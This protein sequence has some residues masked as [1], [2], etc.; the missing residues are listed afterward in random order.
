MRLNYKCCICPHDTSH[1]CCGRCRSTCNTICIFFKAVTAKKW[2]KWLQSFIF[3]QKAMTPFCVR[4]VQNW[5][6]WWALR[7]D[8]ESA[9]LSVIKC[10]CSNFL[11]GLKNK[12]GRD[13][14]IISNS[15]YCQYVI[16]VHLSASTKTILNYKNFKYISALWKHTVVE[17]KLC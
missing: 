3:T 2:R 1:L 10:F 13:R 6:L 9:Y 4:M 7:W 16:K 8:D 5:G 12:S 17:L 11:D 14:G 15:A